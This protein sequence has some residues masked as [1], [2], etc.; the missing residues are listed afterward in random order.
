[1]PGWAEPP[2]RQ[3]RPARLRAEP[4]VGVGLQASTDPRA[5]IPAPSGVG[6]VGRDRG[7]WRAPARGGARWPRAGLP[8]QFLAGKKTG[9]CAASRPRRLGGTPRAAGRFGRLSL[10]VLTALPIIA[11]AAQA[12]A[13]EALRPEV[14]V[15]LHVVPRELLFFSAQSGTWTAV[16]LEAGERVISRGTGENVA[17]VVTD[18]R[19]VGFSSLLSV[20]A[21]I[22]IRAG[23]EDAVEAVVTT[24]NA[25][26]VLTRRH[27]Y[28]FSAFT[29]RWA[30]AE[31]FQP[32]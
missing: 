2:R 17:L 20:A 4:S 24:G 13:A 25:A 9:P 22:P 28:G 29:G 18:L 30:A 12:A 26:S 31:R 21:E 8:A 1:M 6:T 7:G 15:I 19:A 14:N 32:R 16:R 23:S 10:I 3:G 11:G 5:P 27:A